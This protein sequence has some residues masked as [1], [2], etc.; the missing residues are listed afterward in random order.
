MGDPSEIDQDQVVYSRMRSQ[1]VKW[2]IEYFPVYMVKF[3]D[4][5]ST[6]NMGGP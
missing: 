4:L 6:F 1:S 3:K 5:R 2:N